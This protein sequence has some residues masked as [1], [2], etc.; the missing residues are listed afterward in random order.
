MAII[1]NEG[2]GHINSYDLSIWPLDNVKSNPPYDS[3]VASKIPI[4]FMEIDRK[5]NFR[6]SEWEPGSGTPDTDQSGP[7]ETDTLILGVSS[8]ELH[9]LLLNSV[10]KTYAKHIQ[11]SIFLQLLQHSTRSQNFNPSY[12]S[13]G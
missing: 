5:K 3:E 1:Y 10:I 9:I 4:H 8:S 2:K 11:C 6:F 7:E 13:P 12:R